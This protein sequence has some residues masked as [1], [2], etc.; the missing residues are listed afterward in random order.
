VAQWSYAQLPAIGPP[1]RAVFRWT[2]HRSLQ[3]AGSKRVVLHT[4]RDSDRGDRRHYRSL[5]CPGCVA[6]RRLAAPAPQGSVGFSDLDDGGGRASGD[7]VGSAVGHGGHRPHHLGGVDLVTQSTT[8]RAS[9][10]GVALGRALGVSRSGS[11]LPVLEL[12][13]H[14][15]D[16]LHVERMDLDH[17]LIVHVQVDEVEAVIAGSELLGPL[18]YTG[19]LFE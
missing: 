15:Q 9:L 4:A 14:G 6:A 13:H 16:V 11:E 1:R 10:T 5:L 18:L 8:E 2:T 19:Q 3:V 17:L 7:I 12:A